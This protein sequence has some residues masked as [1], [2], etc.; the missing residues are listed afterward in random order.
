MTRLPGHQLGLTALRVFLYSCRCTRQGWTRSPQSP[1]SPLLFAITMEPL[2][3]ALG[4]DSHISGIWYAVKM[5]VLP[6]H[7]NKEAPRL[8]RELLQNPKCLG[9]VALPHIRLYYWAANIRVIQLGIQLEALPVSSQL[10][11]MEL[12]SSKPASLTAL[13]L[14]HSYFFP[15]F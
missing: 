1:Q 12:L 4:S 15:L 13:S 11:F 8:G 7:W 5:N 2:A 14:S 9:G 3:V 6:T 10:N